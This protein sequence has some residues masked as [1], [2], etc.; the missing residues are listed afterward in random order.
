[1]PIFRVKSVKI[2]TGQK[3][4][5]WRR[6]PR[7]RQLSG[8]QSGCILNTFWLKNVWQHGSNS[9]MVN[10]ILSPCS[11]IN[12][13]LVLKRSA[14]SRILHLHVITVNLAV[15]YHLKNIRCWFCHWI[16]FDNCRRYSSCYV[17]ADRVVNLK[18]VTMPPYPPFAFGKCRLCNSSCNIYHLT[19]S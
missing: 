11:R 10:M 3:N 18:M 4:L 2:Y 5:H 7:R 16:A 9:R 6:R 19:K 12:K 15:I 14:Y 13:S 1:M 8:M 17:P